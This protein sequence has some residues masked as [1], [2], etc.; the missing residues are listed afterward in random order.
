MEITTAAIRM[1]LLG[2]SLSTIRANESNGQCHKYSGKLI[3]PNQTSNR[4]DRRTRFNQACDPAEIISTAP[5]VGNNAHVPGK[6]RS[7]V[8]TNRPVTMS[9]APK[10]ACALPKVLAFAWDVGA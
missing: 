3:N 9:A 8:M 7:L 4:F 6:C 2:C 5:S 10:S 1:F